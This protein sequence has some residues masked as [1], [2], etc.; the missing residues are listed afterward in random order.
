M[1]FKIIYQYMFIPCELYLTFTANGWTKFAMG[2]C[3][4][5]ENGMGTVVVNGVDR[6]CANTTLGLT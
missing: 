6:R 4:K 5:R 2:K 1:K 3:C